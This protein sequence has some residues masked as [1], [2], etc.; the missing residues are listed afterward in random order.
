MIG[1]NTKSTDL[2]GPTAISDQAL[3]IYNLFPVK[4]EGFSKIS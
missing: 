4:L 1:S 3:T 2:I